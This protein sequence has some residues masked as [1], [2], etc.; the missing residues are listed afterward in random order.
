MKVILLKD[1]KKLGRKDEIVEVADGYGMNYLIPNG[2]AVA[3]STKS[4]KILKQEKR[5]EEKNR[6]EEKKAAEEMKNQIEDLTLEFAVKT[7]EN[8]RV[9]GS[10]STKQIE[11]R[12]KEKYDL[13]VDKRKFSPSK[14]LNLLGLN[15]INVKLFDG[16]EA[17]LKVRLV[18]ED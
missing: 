11:S 13:D 16:V 1:V 12:L 17:E 15:T 7:G 6:Q 14:A 18:E 10:V 4:R 8:G 5:E 3:A 9:F 2:L